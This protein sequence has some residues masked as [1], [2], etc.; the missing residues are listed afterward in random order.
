MISGTWLAWLVNLT[1]SY[2]FTLFGHSFP[3][4]IAVYTLI[5]NLVVAIG[6]SAVMKLVAHE[7]PADQ[8]VAADYY[9]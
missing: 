8:T 9:A 2:T 5:L 3:G 4:Y 1:P 6:L 7:E